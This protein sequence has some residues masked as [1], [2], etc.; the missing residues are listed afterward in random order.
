MKKISTAIILVLMMTLLVVGPAAAQ[1]GKINIKGEVTAIGGGSLTV[2][3]NKGETYVI[4]VPAGIDVSSIQV[5]YSVM[6]K[7]NAGEG[8]GWEAESIKIVGGT[9]ESDNGDGEMEVE[10]EEQENE[11]VETED[12][13]EVEV[14]AEDKEDKEKSEGF[15][16]NS[17][18]CAE[19]KQDKPHPLAPKIATRYGVPEEVVMGYFCEGY[20]IGAIMLAIKTSQLEG[21]TAD[22]GELLANRSTGNGWGQIWKSLGL[23]GSEKKGHSPP[24]LL[25]KPDH[26][27]PKN[28]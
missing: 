23:I 15:K 25:K 16:D 18:F 21:V 12:E 7:A 20:S 11:E 8:G 19:G 28:K 4:T 22:T 10:D 3:N 9:S 24:G 13:D 14:E 26:A 1:K 27:G 5:G 6:V 17:A 2:Q